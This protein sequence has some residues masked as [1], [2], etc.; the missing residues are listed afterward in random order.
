M[1]RKEAFIKISEL[2]NRVKGLRQFKEVLKAMIGETTNPLSLGMKVEFLNQGMAKTFQLELEN[3]GVYFHPNHDA[4]KEYILDCI[5]DRITA[6]E[7]E[8][9]EL[10]KD[11]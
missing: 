3:L 10:Y 2:E 9:E 5:D 11:E 4:D 8:I 1:N 6:V 7:N